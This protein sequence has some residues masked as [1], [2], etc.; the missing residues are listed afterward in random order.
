MELRDALSQAIDER[1]GRGY[2]SD[3][4]TRRRP[5]VMFKYLT[6]WDEGAYRFTLNT[7]ANVL[8]AAA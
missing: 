1:I 8:E 6:E 2:L 4:L 5:E 7:S 3:Y